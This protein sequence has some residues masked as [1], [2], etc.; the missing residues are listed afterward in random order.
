M[1]DRALKKF[2]IFTILCQILHFLRVNVLKAVVLVGTFS[3]AMAF[4]GNDLV[5]FIGIPLTSLASYQ[6]FMSAGGG[7]A[8][9]F[10]L[11]AL[12]KPAQENVPTKTTAF[13]T[14]TLR[15]CRI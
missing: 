2:V 4:A 11:G 10:M 8:H 5:N 14:F 15:K 13:S 6:E 3:L 1:R 12:N 9:N 7:D